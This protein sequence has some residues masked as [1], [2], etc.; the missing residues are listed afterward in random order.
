VNQGPDASAVDRPAPGSHDRSTP[1]GSLETSSANLFEVMVAAREAQAHGDPLAER[2]TTFYRTLMS[3]TVLL[4]VPPNHG[5]EA[6]D[7]LASAVNDDQEVEISVMLAR[8]AA[9][10]PVNVLFGSIAAL[11]AWSPLGTANLPLPARIAFA[12]LAANGLPAILDPAG[13]VPYEFDAAEVSALAAGQ[14]P[15]TGEPLFPPT[16]RSSL[17]LRLAGPESAALEARITD[18]LRGGPVDEA[19]LVE[20]E[21]DDGAHLLLGL[22]GSEGATAT[23]DVPAGTDLVWLEEP[24]L[25]SVRRVARP[26]YRRGRR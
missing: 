9:G 3:G 22:V 2:L 13:P 15:L 5:D 23:V 26:F 18:A 6:R 24:L 14:I 8:D 16:H 19:Y 4:P 25:S 11:A 12:N 21:T 17:R 20:S 1:S 7:A 10:Q